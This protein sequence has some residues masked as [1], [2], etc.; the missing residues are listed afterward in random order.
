[1]RADLTW[2]SAWHDWLATDFTLYFFCTATRKECYENVLNVIWKK[3]IYWRSE[4]D[5]MC[6]KHSST[7]AAPKT[8]PAKRWKEFL[9]KLPKQPFPTGS[10]TLLIG[11]HKIHRNLVSLFFALCQHIKFCKT[12]QQTR[13]NNSAKSHADEHRRNLLPFRKNSIS[14]FFTGLLF[15]FISVGIL[16]SSHEELNSSDRRS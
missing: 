4:S 11:K 12:K 2:A 9:N 8:R 5:R 14:L 6:R 13:K 10:N 1:M 16:W 15:L 3:F 7:K